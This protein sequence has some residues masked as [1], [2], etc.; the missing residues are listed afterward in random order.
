MDQL[1]ERSRVDFFRLQI[2]QI[3][4]LATDEEI[5]AAIV[6]ARQE[7]SLDELPDKLEDKVL[8][9]LAPP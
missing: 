9:R 3:M 1:T 2:R 4:P 5:D 8:K 7:L 6:A